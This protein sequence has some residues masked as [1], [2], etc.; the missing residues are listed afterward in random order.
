MMK[1]LIMV[2]LALVLVACADETTEAM[3]PPVVETPATT[4]PVEEPIVEPEP[5]PEPEPEVEPE[6]EPEPDPVMEEEEDESEP[7]LPL[8][9]RETLSEYD[10]RDGRRAYIAIDGMVYDVTT[11][12]R[13]P[14][15]NHNG[16]QA[17]Q[18]L[19]AQIPQDHRADMRFERFPVVGTYE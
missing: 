2:L 13:W 8:F 19:S 1:S 5:T 4:T 9:N 10:G 11:S 18:D 17:G 14:N 16:Y 6:P 12:S 7:V 15:G 3:A